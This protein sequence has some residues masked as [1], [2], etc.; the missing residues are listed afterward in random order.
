MNINELT[1]GQIKEIQNMTQNPTSKGCAYTNLCGFNV[2]VRTVTMIYTGKIVHVYPNEI[3][4]ENAC[5]IPET[6]RWSESL[7]TCEFKEVEPYINSVIINK[8]AILDVTEIAKLP[9]EVK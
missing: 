6:N 2:L 8:G 1:L 9:T 3:L 7:K 4:L 5:W